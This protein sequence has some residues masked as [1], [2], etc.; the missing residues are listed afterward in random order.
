MER[1]RVEVVVVGEEALGIRRGRR[2]RVG[3]GRVWV[4]SEVVSERLAR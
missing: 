1:E 4:V 3:E 2:L